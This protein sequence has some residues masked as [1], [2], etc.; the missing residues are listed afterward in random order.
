MFI[1]TSWDKEYENF[2]SRWSLVVGRW[3]LANP[4]AT[5]SPDQVRPP[6]D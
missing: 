5:K 6:K 4:A 1:R 2:V 3:S